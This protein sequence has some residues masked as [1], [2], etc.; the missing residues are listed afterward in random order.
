MGFTKP[1]MH[2]DYYRTQHATFGRTGF[3]E[4]FDAC[5]LFVI[6]W[7]FF[8]LGTTFNESL[9]WC[10]SLRLCVLASSMCLLHLF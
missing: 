10:K 8:L 7:D 4:N 6:Q 2:K 3:C 9:Y 5:S 1:T